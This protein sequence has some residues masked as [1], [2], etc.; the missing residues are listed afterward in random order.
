MRRT[1]LRLLVLGG[2]LLTMLSVLAAADLWVVVATESSG[3]N[4]T[5]PD[6]ANNAGRYTSIVLD[7]AGNPVVR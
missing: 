6:P 4:I 2:G 1:R 7:Q 3:N 5:S